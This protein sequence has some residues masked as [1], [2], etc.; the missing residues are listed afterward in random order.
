MRLLKIILDL[1]KKNFF[2]ASQPSPMDKCKCVA[3]SIGSGSNRSKRELRSEE[4]VKYL[5]LFK[6]ALH[7]RLLLLSFLACFT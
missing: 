1:I 2:L 4:T 3:G 6:K 5:G 7:P